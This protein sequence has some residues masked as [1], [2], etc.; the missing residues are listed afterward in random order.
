MKYV[1]VLDGIG[2][3]VE[4]ALCIIVSIFKWKCDIRNCSCYRAVKLVEHGM[5]LER[6]LEKRLCR[7]VT[8]DQIKFGFMSEREKVDAMFILRRL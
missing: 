8:V 2:I 5:L 4:W 7:I 1:R 6:V 3:L